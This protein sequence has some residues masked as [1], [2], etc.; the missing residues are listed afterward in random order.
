MFKQ[1]EITEKFMYQRKV[2]PLRVLCLNEVVAKNL[3]LIPLQRNMRL[4]DNLLTEMLH[5]SL[6][7][8]CIIFINITFYHVLLKI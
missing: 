7:K 2:W 5:E 1:I 3:L 4:L 6:W 8:Y